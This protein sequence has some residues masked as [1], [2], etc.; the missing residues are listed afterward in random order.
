VVYALSIQ[1]QAIASI[2]LSAQVTDNLLVLI[3]GQTSAFVF[4]PYPHV[5]RSIPGAS[6]DDMFGHRFGI[7]SIGFVIQAILCLPLGTC[8]N[9]GQSWALQFVSFVIVVGV[10][11]EFCIAYMFTSTSHLENMPEI[12]S[13]MKRLV[14]V[15]LFAYAFVVTV[16]SWMNEK[17]PEV[18]ATKVLWGTMIGCYVLHVVFGVLGALGHSHVGGNV[19]NSMQHHTT[20][21]VTHIAI[22]LFNFGVI[23]P[24]IPIYA[25]ISRYNLMEGKFLS[26]NTAFFW[27]TVA[28]W[29]AALLLCG[30]K[31]FIET[32]TWGG[33]VLSSLLEFIV[34]A[35]LYLRLK[36]LEGEGGVIVDE[37]TPIAPKPEVHGDTGHFQSV[38][39]SGFGTSAAALHVTSTDRPLTDEEQEDCDSEFRA[40]PES[41][42]I[43]GK[44][45]AYIILV[46]TLGMLAY[47]IIQDII[48]IVEG[49]NVPTD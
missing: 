42:P 47:T 41:F 2:I 10:L 1:T 36:H 37:E 25:I 48:Y 23:L 6:T 5:M 12:G 7:V 17:R 46:S 29:L 16:P 18:S 40:V 11:L 44:M 4:T 27:S 14:G 49:K 26:P 35:L 13:D 3:F 38:Q 9:L 24:G 19:F 45:C 21:V 15:C 8:F 39:G 43:S 22:F 31:G 30:S 33:V 34:P 32:V 28:P 20:S